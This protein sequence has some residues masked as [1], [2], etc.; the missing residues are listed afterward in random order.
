MEKIPLI[1]YGTIGL[2]IIILISLSLL[3]LAGAVDFRRVYNPFTRQLDYYRSSNFTGENITADYFIG[4]GT[5]LT[6]IT[7]GVSD[8]WVNI[9]GDNIIR[10]LFT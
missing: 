8:D 4:D 5:Q 9:T 7:T 1:K 3:D 10:R 6:G 2:L